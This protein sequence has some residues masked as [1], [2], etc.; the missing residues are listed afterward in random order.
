MAASLDRAAPSTIAERA[1]AAHASSPARPRSA[2]ARSS[3]DVRDHH[4][5][6]WLSVSATTRASAARRGRRRPLLLRRPTRSSTGWSTRGELLEWAVV[7]G[8]ARYG[9]PRGPVEDA[10]GRRPR[11][12]CSR[13]TCRAPA[14]CGETMPEALF[15][16]LAPPSLG[17]AG[18]P[19]GRPRHRGR[20]GAR[21]PAGHRAGRAGRRGGVRRDRR[22]RRRSPGG[23]GVGSLDGRSPT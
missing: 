11:R 9:T 14:R 6:V 13:S 2:R 3:A 4:P 23:R 19:A 22:Q 16:F 1:R 15:V 8:A 20:G 21:A 12:R 5:E 10:L 7:H 18:P 17:G